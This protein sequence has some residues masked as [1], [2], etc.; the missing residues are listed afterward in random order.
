MINTNL[1]NYDPKIWKLIIKE[2]KRQESY[3]NLIASENYVSSSILEA[4]GSCL[5]N[6]YA[7]GYI[8]NRFYNGCNII[9]KIEKIAIKRA[10]KLF[11]VEYVN[12][13]PHSG[14]QA[15]FSVFNALLKPNDIILGMNLNHGGHLTHGSTVN[16]S[17]KL[18][19][20]FSYGVNKC[21]EIDYDA[22][23][24]L[25]HLHRPKMIIGGFSAYSGICDWKYM[26]KI[27]D[28]INAYFFVDI[29]H[30]VGLIVAGIYPNPLK[31]AHVVSTTTHK[32][33]GGPR[34]GLIIS[35]CGN[36]K[37]YSKLDSSVFPGSQ[38][39]PLMHVIAAKAISFKEALEPKF[40]L[41][42]KNILFFS[43]KMVKIFLKRNFSVIS[44]KTN[45][46]LFL[47]DLSEKKISGKEASNILAL[48]R[49]IVNKNTIPNDSQSPYITSGIRIG[50]PAIVKRG[51]SIKYVI[52][53]TNWICDI[54][55]EPNNL[56]KIKKISKK[57]KKICYKY[58][59]YNKI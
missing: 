13:Q 42:Q 40:F 17:G 2:K 35:N 26:R 36:K 29:S 41:L 33:L 31:Y 23:K 19:K 54:L 1:K 24:Y 15:N 22:L 43:K 7:E 56:I 55:N 38:G 14:S 45:N 10:K 11:N 34:G 12:V 51:I 48:A 18:Y 8:G 21:G 53:I 50:T 44:G 59:I 28:E 6:K 16:F 52:K 39:G 49:I 20:S 30:I 9:D 37:I 58:P 5:T 57:I 3:I 4:Q 46:H 47:I 27:A 25:S 32:T